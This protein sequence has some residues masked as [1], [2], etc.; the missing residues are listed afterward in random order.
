MKMN[1]ICKITFRNK[2]YNYKIN[3]RNL[4]TSIKNL[5]KYRT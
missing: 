3:S 2:E 1:Q 4:N 5:K